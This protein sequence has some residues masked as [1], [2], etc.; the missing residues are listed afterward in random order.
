MIYLTS[1]GFIDQNNKA[2][3]RFGQKKFIDII[4]KISI[5]Q[6]KEQKEILES[7]LNKWQKDEKQRD[8]ITLVGIKI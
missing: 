7:E 3:K 8:D 6:I 5:K 1:D 4:T 2:R